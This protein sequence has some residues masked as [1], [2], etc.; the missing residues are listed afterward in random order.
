MAVFAKER[1]AKLVLIRRPFDK[2]LILAVRLR[3]SEEST[4]D[5]VLRSLIC[6]NSCLGETR[7]ISNLSIGE[8]VCFQSKANL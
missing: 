1:Y 3:R 4:V 5:D 7:R 2:F 8:S 6:A